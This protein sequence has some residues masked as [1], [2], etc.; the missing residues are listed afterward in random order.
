MAADGHHNTAEQR[1][2]PR[3]TWKRD[4]EKEMWTAGYKYMA[5]D[6]GGTTRQSWVETRVFHPER[7]G[8]SSAYG[9][10]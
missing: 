8:I 3:N 7:Q 1:G 6:V 4:L 10:I 2:R 9:A 5:K